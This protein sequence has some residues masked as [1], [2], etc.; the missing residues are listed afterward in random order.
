MAAVPVAATQG[1][2]AVPVAAAVRA[3]G[4]AKQFLK[5]RKGSFAAFYILRGS[6]LITIAF[7]G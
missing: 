1:V 2:A 5:R 4:K 7:R 6:K 3:V